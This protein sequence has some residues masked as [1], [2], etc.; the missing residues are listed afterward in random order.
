MIGDTKLAIGTRRAGR[1]PE[2]WQHFDAILNV[3]DMEYEDIHNDC[4]ESSERFYLQ[5]PVKEGKRDKSELERWMAVGIVFCLMHAR[6]KRRILIHCAQGKDRSVA[7]AMAVIVLFCDLTFPLRWKED[8]W[9]LNVDNLIET[10]PV[11]DDD[12]ASSLDKEDLQYNSSGLSNT[13]VSAL[14]GKGWS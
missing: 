13:L 2:C 12:E 9:R 1:P 4:V 5:L 7:V 14:Q 8:L 6:E 3:T 10:I 11:A